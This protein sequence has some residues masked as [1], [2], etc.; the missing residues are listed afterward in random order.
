M[1]PPSFKPEL[2]GDRFA[3]HEVP[4]EVLK[5]FAAFEELLMEVAK[6]EYLADHPDRLRIPKGFTKG[7]ELRLASIEEGSAKLALVLAGLSLADTSV[8][9]Q[10]AHDKIVNTIANVSHGAEPGLAPELLRYFDRFGRSLREGERIA[11]QRAE[12]GQTSLTPEVRQKLLHASQ[13]EEWT[14]EMLLKGRVGAADV[15]DGEFE[16]ELADGTKLKAPLEHQHNETV[17]AALGEYLHGRMLALKGV[18][19]KDKSGNFK[20]I[21]SVEHVNLL[22]PLDVETRLE[23]LANL[24]DR[25][26]NG[27]GIALDR[28]S[29]KALAEEFEK[30]FDTSLPLPHLYPTPEGGILAEWTLGEW[31]ISLEI[32]TTSQTAQYEALH[33]T[34]DKSSELNLN[35]NEPS[36]WTSLNSEL[37]RLNIAAESE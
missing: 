6:R 3:N 4:L 22:H 27:K 1:P 2:I 32:E 15:A 23:E 11:F 7:V 36:A 34:S 16:L 13:A 17:I 5:D 28:T 19:R 10:R 14:E 9:I 33:L 21:D 30:N 24:K 35:L 37:Q 25:W 12:G 29:L 20:R 18:V 31:A 26:L 8:Y